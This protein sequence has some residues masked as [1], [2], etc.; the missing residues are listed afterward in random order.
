MECQV[1]AARLAL[2]EKEH[3]SMI[4]FQSA[5]ITRGPDP[6]RTRSASSYKV[7]PRR[8]YSPFSIPQCARTDLNSKC[9]L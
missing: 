1:A 6:S 2:P 7:R 8:P 9:G 3:K 4:K 5:A